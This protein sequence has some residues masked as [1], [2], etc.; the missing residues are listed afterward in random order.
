MLLLKH[1]TLCSSPGHLGKGFIRFGNQQRPVAG[2][3]QISLD[4]E[5]CICNCNCNAAQRGDGGVPCQG[6]FDIYASRSFFTSMSYWQRGT[7]KIVLL[8][9]SV[10]TVPNN[11]Q[12][13]VWSRFG[14]LTRSPSSGRSGRKKSTTSSLRHWSCMVA[15][16]VRYKVRFGLSLSLFI[17]L[18]Y[19]RL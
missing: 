10:V 15:L 5:W 19:I 12:P 18:P 7:E 3:C 8:A 4:D 11:L 17:F 1:W 16:G 13:N 6:T 2:S 14:S 9:Y